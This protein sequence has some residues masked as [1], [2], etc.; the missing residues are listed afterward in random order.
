M[1]LIY[2]M[3]FFS[4][5]FF[6]IKT[7]VVAEGVFENKQDFIDADDTLYGKNALSRI[8]TKGSAQVKTTS[9][10]EENINKP[11]NY[12]DKE[13][14][15]LEE[16]LI[17]E[18][19]YLSV[20]ENENFSLPRKTSKEESYDVR[21]AITFVRHFADLYLLAQ[22][23]FDEALPSVKKRSYGFLWRDIGNATIKIW[24]EGELCLAKQIFRHP[25]F[26][27]LH[28]DS[29][30]TLIEMLNKKFTNHFKSFIV[31]NACTEEVAKQEFFRFYSQL[32]EKM[33]V[34]LK[35]NYPSIDN[36]MI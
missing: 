18:F 32:P 33:V 31:Q 23:L 1:K 12:K 5:T 4:V 27:R 8:V 7:S 28:P 15:D 21:H 22:R 36:S 29:Q 10:K 26:R 35:R 34:I 13:D 19:D 24:T 30:R 3:L 9:K 20:G 6:G 11:K 14:Y 16:D 17:F 2:F 25:S